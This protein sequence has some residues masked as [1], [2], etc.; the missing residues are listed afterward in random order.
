MALYPGNLGG[1]FASDIAS[2]TRLATSAAFSRYL[3]EAIYEQ[4]A[5]IKSG[6][7]ATNA[8]LNNTTG[9]RIE[10]PFFNSL[11]TVKETVRSDNTWG[12]AGTGSLTAQK[13]TA[14]TQYASILHNG[15]AYAMDD[16][17]KFAT[18]EDAL[19]HVRSQM[20]QDMDRMATTTLI[21]MLTGILGPGGT[22]AG[23][24][25]L[26][27]SEAT[28]G[29]ETDANFI[30]MTNVTRAKFLSGERAGSLQTLVVHS[31]VASALQV[32]GALQFS[33][34]ALASGSGIQWGGGGIGL[35]NTEV[36]AAFGLRVIV[37][38]QLPIRGTTGENA[39]YVSYLLGAGAIQTGSQYPLT[40]LSDY[41][42]LSFQTELSCKFSNVYHLNGVTWSSATDNPEDTALANPSNWNRVFTEPK[43]IPAVE[44][45][46]NSP[47][48][49]L[50]P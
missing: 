26:D 23:S 32:A 30:N 33:S 35:T 28:A 39:Q 45:V 41:N 20:T 17:S 1:T 40:V 27:V 24:N 43:L 13:V 38:D 25:S 44:L 16:L 31:D 42:H 2:V 36:G 47:M 18:G 50:I 46:C 19:N 29:S 9:T 3:A 22:L 11:S 49:G 37:D 14:A 8:V 48:G 6:A 5:F 10:V 15:F 34:T 21:S 4:S 7:L 12:T